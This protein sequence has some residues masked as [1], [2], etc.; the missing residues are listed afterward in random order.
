[1][2]G[3]KKY[4][5]FEER[6]LGFKPSKKYPWDD[7]EYVGVTCPECKVQFVELSIDNLKTSK[8]SQCLK[9]IRKCEAYRE[10][11]GAVEPPQKRTKTTQEQ[12]DEVLERLR[13]AEEERRALHDDMR[14]GFRAA[15]DAAGLGDPAATERHDLERRLREKALQDRLASTRASLFYEDQICGICQETTADRLL[16]PCNH[17]ET[18]TACWSRVASLAA[19]RQ[20]PARCPNCRMIVAHTLRVTRE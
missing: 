10:R 9:H 12:L 5:D 15:S 6:A 17:R 20:E 3:R 1:M 8:A 13:R 2:A 7:V 18:C 11:S 4:T 14:A 19:Q 16:A